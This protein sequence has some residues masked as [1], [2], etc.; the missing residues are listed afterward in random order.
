MRTLRYALTAIVLVALLPHALQGQAEETGAVEAVAP[1]ELTFQPYEED[2]GAR[3]AVLYGNP[4]ESGPFV[5]R[6]KLP[7][8]WT[9]RPHTHGGTELV[10]FLSGTCYFAHGDPLTR[11]AA[12]KM[13]PGSFIALPAGTRMRGFS[14]EQ[15]CV[16]DVHGEGPFTTRYLD[17]E[18]GGGS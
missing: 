16:V 14:G 12:K 8:E 9:G 7:P 10:T 17:E 1:D 5:V 3:I 6:F 4:A 15:G 13:P 18:G 11:E 2:P